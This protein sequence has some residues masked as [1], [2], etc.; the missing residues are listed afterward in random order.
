M[1]ELPDAELPD[2]NP[3][4]GA[5]ILSACQGGGRHVNTTDSA[6][7][8]HLP[9]GIVVNVRTNVHNIKNKAKALSVLGAIHAA[10]WQ[11]ATGQRLPV[12]TCWG[13]AI[14]A[15][16][17]PYL[18]LHRRGVTDHRINPTPTALMED[19]VMDML[20]EPIIQEHRPTNGGV[21]PSR[22]TEY[23]HC[24]RKANQLQRAK[25]AADAEICWSMLPAEGRT[26][27]RL[28]NAAD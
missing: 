9:T 3:A 6:Q 7:P 23:Q 26:F 11:T 13:V 12:V 5:L 27:T 18:Q 16:P 20:I 2:I 1:P 28:V 4:D 15:T 10:E 19:G 14:A 8:Y 24:L 21:G 25:P 17:Q 22:I